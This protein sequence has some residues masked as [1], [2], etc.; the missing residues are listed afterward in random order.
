MKA[1]HVFTEVP[2]DMTHCQPVSFRMKHIMS[3]QAQKE[4]SECFTHIQRSAKLTLSS[5][6]ILVGASGGG[7]GGEILCKVVYG[8]TKPLRKRCCSQDGSWKS[9][10]IQ[11]S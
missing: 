2:A 10:S 9:G 4:T 8:Y 1:F 5:S 7:R 3:V 11:E 6:N